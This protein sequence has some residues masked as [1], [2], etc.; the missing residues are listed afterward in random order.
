[1]QLQKNQYVVFPD[2]H[3][4]G[5]LEVRW[6]ENDQAFYTFIETE[7]GENEIV[8]SNNIITVERKKRQ[9]KKQTDISKMKEIFPCFETEKAYAVCDG[10]NGCISRH[11]TKVFY[12]YYAKSIC[13][14]KDGK[15]YAPIWA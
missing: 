12:K 2:G 13:I 1:M 6:S 4:E 11:N 7:N 14:E 9:Y 15:I 8:F 3:K 5:W 10:T